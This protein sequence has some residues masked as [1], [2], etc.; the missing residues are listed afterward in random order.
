MLLLDTLLG[1]VPQGTFTFVPRPQSAAP[2]IRLSW[3]LP[4]LMLCLFYS[5]NK[6]ASLERLHVL[7]WAIRSAFLRKRLSEALRGERRADDILI[8]YEPALERVLAFAISEHLVERLPN[9]RFKLSEKGVSF[10]TYIL[11]DDAVLL[12][13]RD[14]LARWG[15]VLTEK[16]V[17]NLV[18]AGGK[19]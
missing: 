12:D 5:R 17:K 8:R 10:S 11:S 3:R 19:R 2:E 16:A 1:K 13:E 4:M 15:M 6:C 7:N 18:G 9:S 14:W